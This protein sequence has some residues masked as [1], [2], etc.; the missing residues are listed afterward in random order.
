MANLRGSKEYFAKL[1]M[2]IRWMIK[3]LGPPTI[4]LTLATAEWFSEPFLQYL[5]TINSSI[6][7]VNNMTP[8]ELC[9]MDPV[10]VSVHFK[11]KWDSIFNKLIKGKTNPPFGE[12]TDHFWRI[13][14]QSR[15]AAHVHCVLWVKDAPILG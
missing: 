3:E 13:E 9:A 7:N 6:P 10:N 8:A 11:K 4:F 12:V 15:G 1:S 5:R 2:N 14:Y